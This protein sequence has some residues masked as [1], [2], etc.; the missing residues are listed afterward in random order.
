MR[1]LNPIQKLVTVEYRWNTII[2]ENCFPGVRA[3]E[4]SLLHSSRR[5]DIS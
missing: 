5:T 2:V 3:W 4:E 1:R